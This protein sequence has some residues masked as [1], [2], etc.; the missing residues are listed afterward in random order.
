MITLELPKDIK[1]KR[2]FK[3]H[4]KATK[5][6][7][8]SILSNIP[9]FWPYNEIFRKNFK[10]NANIDIRHFT[11]DPYDFKYDFDYNTGNLNIKMIN[12]H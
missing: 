9:V 12:Q 7:A 10:H 4:K 8:L 1:F 6:L 3:N 11:S 5:N 2:I